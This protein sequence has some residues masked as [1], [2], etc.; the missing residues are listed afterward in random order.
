MSDDDTPYPT[1]IKL[2]QRTR[3]LE[4]AFGDGASFMLPAEYLRV[5]SPSA[6]TQ[7]ER[8]RGRWVAG[9]EQVAITRITPVGNYA[10]RLSFDD[11]HDT[12][13][14]S[15]QTLYELG[16]A[17]EQ[18]WRA[19]L[20]GLQAQGVARRAQAGGPRLRLL[21]FARLV[22][23]LGRS[24]EEIEAP[25]SVSTVAALLDWLRQ[26]GG[27]WATFLKD[28]DVR[29]TVNREFAAPERPV[30]DGDEVAI[31]PSHPH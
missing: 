6:D 10:I 16:S 24:G 11:G 14:Y 12:G 3:T 29:V 2:H 27:H 13:V 15:W 17:Q 22:D 26:R 19:Y 23:R 1:E 28:Q 4:L 30:H 31:V 9:R 8:E 25:A 18:N 5:Y 20:D 7:L 21:Y